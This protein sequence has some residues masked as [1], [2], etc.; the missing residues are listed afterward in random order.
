MMKRQFK[1]YGIDETLIIIEDR[2][3]DTLQNVEYVK[4]IM[5]KNKS[6]IRLVLFIRK[7]LNR[8]FFKIINRI[9]QYAIFWLLV[10]F[11]PV[12]DFHDRAIVK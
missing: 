5:E 3:K 2:S 11:I 7:S 1:E 10:I 4:S 8:K 6:Y 12:A 9:G